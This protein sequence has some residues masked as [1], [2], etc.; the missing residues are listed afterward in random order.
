MIFVGAGEARAHKNHYKSATPHY[1]SDRRLKLI[2]HLHVFSPG[3]ADLWDEFL[4]ERGAER[5]SQ[6]KIHP[7]IKISAESTVCVSVL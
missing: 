3:V 1:E 7:S 5:P 4:F 6:T 2:E